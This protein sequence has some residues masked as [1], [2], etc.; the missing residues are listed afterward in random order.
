MAR[1]PEFKVVNSIVAAVPVNVVDSFVAE[2]WPF[3]VFRHDKAMFEHS[4]ARRDRIG[5]VWPIG[6]HVVVGAEPLPSP[7]T[8]LPYGNVR[9]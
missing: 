1:G 4:T 9:V 6:H 3:Q 5:M 2:Q 7:L 8:G